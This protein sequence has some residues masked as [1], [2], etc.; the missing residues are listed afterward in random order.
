MTMTMYLLLLVH[1]EYEYDLFQDPPSM[2]LTMTINPTPVKKP[3][4]VC[5]NGCHLRSIVIRMMMLIT[6]R[7]MMMM[8]TVRQ[9]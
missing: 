8:T 1:H 3:N 6:M 9:L 2:Y 7:K 5:R 4:M